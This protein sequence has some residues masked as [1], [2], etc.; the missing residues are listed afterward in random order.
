M[1]IAC[2]NVGTLKSG[3]CECQVRTWE[4]IHGNMGTCQL[5]NGNVIGNVGTRE[6]D[7][8]RGNIHWERL[9]QGRRV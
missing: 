7:R 6:R 3:P 4:H 1:Q 5:N 8:E 9:G 2:G